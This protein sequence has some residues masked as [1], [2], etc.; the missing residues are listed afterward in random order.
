MTTALDRTEPHAI[1][2]SRQFRKQRAQ[3]PALWLE[4]SAADRAHSLLYP[5]LHPKKWGMK[6]AHL[7]NNFS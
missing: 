3:L 7:K 2:E 6:S 1:N 5:V 4:S